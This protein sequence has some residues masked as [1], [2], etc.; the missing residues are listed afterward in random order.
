MNK[1]FIYVTFFIAVSFN[2]LIISCRRTTE[3][4]VQ[5]NPLESAQAEVK[6]NLNDSIL[7]VDVKTFLNDS[8]YGGYGYDVYVNDRLAVHQP[9]I[10]AI[11]GNRGFSTE[12]KA[13]KAGELVSEKV[14]QKI[15]PPSVTTA[16]L[17][18]IGVLD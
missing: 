14:K 4:N 13:R 2:I 7:E 8:V 17:D 6:A 1:N 16:E 15:R 12:E 10:P 9:N 5:G 3:G 18:S 11:S